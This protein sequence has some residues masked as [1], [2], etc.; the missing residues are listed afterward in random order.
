M[1]NYEDDSLEG[2]DGPKYDKGKLR[3]TLIPPEALKGLAEVLTFGADK[4]EANSWTRVPNG[5][6]RYL[7][8]LYRHLEAYRSGEILDPESKLHHL[9]HALCN[10]AFVLSLEER[11]A[12]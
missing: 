9:K 1:I 7:D 8:A 5:K 4:Y 2:R 10:V 6:E 12:V 3:Y 11:D